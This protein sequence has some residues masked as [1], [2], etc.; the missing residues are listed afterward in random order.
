MKTYQ[1]K[2][3]T[4]ETIFEG[5]YNSPKECIKDAVSNNGVKLENTILD[6]NVFTETEYFQIVGELMD[7]GIDGMVYSVNSFLINVAIKSILQEKHIAALKAIKKKI[8]A[9]TFEFSNMCNGITVSFKIQAT[10]YCYATILQ[11][12]T[13]GSWCFGEDVTGK[14]KNEIE[15]IK[16]SYNCNDADLRIVKK[17]TKNSFV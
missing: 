1:I 17:R 12:K 14:N 7:N 15:A 16:K 6:T 10:E 9:T 8:G 4:G 11:Y 13:Y 3:I 5:E 2:T